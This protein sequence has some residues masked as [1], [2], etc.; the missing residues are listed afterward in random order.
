MLLQSDYHIHASFYRVKKAG[1]TVGPRACEQVA[2]ARAAGSR[3]IGIV[4]HCNASPCHPFHCLEELSAEYYA[5]GFDRENV[6]LGVEADLDDE[7][8]DAC[9]RCGR[10]KLRLHYVIGSVHLSPVQEPDAA[11]YI[12]LEYKRIVNALKRNDN[13]DIIGHPFGEG[14]R[15]EKS[16]AVARWSWEMIP[17]AYLDEILSLAIENGKALEI[18]RCN[19][20]DP[21]YLDFL[22]RMRDAGVLFSVGSDAHFPEGVG[23][24]A[25]RTKQL[26]AIG[27]SEAKHWRVQL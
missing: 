26:E 25:V 9:G 20:E 1:A 12:S 7:G 2:A 15:W 16:G 3:L 8:N 22:K 11:R 17:T 14:M 13:I 4:E 6:F 5:P 27:F 24:A 21:V 10:D 23:D 18:N 19:M